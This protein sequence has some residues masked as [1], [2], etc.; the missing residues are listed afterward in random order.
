MKFMVKNIFRNIIILICFSSSAVIAL[1]YGKDCSKDCSDCD[2]EKEC[3]LLE[4]KNT[5]AWVKAD[6]LCDSKPAITKPNS[7]KRL[8]FE[9]L[10]K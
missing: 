3:L 2:T 4:R 5:C 10:S 6:D 1:P 9:N 7:T 8:P